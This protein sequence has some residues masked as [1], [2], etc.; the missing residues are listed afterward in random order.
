MSPYKKVEKPVGE[1]YQKW[2]QRT[3][4]RINATGSQED[5]M[6]SGGGKGSARFKFRHTAGEEGNESG[7]RGGRGGRGSGWRGDQAGAGIGLSGGGGG[8]HGGGR[9]GGDEGMAV[10]VEP[11]NPMLKAPGTQRLKLTCDR[12]LTRFEFNLTSQS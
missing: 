1:M 3:H 2:A 6:N 7:G 10:Q 11:T 5:P 8:Q 12:L 9:G 4:K